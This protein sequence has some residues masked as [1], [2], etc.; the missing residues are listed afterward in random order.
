MNPIKENRGNK[1]LRVIRRLPT[2][3]GLSSGLAI[4]MFLLLNCQ[5][6]VRPI[7]LVFAEAA[8][9]GLKQG[10]LLS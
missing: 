10:C 8:I 2:F 3:E 6:Y 4:I 7:H 5:K 1:G 9:K